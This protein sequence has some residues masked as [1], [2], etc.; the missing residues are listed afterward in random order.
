MLALQL[1]CTTVGLVP[2]P[3]T[4]VVHS[5]YI[6]GGSDPVMLSAPSDD[7]IAAKLATM[8]KQSKKGRV[9]PQR[10]S[11]ERSD[12]PRQ[13]VLP[14]SESS[15][16]PV[17]E[18]PEELRMPGAPR[19]SSHGYHISMEDVFPGLGLAESWESNSD[20]RRDLRRALR[21]DL[22]VPPVSWNEKQARAVF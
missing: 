9:A 1:M 16:I 3:A 12:V 19:S 7:V 20:L 11:S 14:S 10:C 2:I 18:V 17:W 22:F 15:S 21:S 13:T 4:R 6:T 5:R 8:R